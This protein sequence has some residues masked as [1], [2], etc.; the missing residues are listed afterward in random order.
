MDASRWKQGLVDMERVVSGG[1]H[2]FCY[3][4]RCWI[5]IACSLVAVA[6]RGLNRCGQANKGAGGMSRR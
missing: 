3:F 6:E 4:R 5:R 2:L 1:R